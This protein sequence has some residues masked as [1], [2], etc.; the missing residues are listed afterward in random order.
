M[1]L[2]VLVYNLRQFRDDWEAAAVAVAGTRPDVALLQECGT[3]RKLHRFAE[4][5]EMRP[6]HGR[7]WPFFRLV[8]DAVLVRPPWRLID[9]RLHRFER[10]TRFYP[11]GAY[12]AQVG[13]SGVR[14]WAVSTHLGLVDEERVRHARELTD[15]A[16]SLKPP[17]LIGGDFNEGPDGRAV[18]WLGE[19]YFDA[20]TGGG[21]ETFPATDPRARIDML[22][23]TPEVVVE[24]AV[25]LDGPDVLQGSDHRPLVVDL[26]VDG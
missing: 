14:V 4:A 6:A 21:G 5:L 2:R 7:L 3:T 10:S 8:R 12:L 23:T 24:R 15:L 17:L 20:W 19:R 22:F 11:R 26:R 9:G 13:R 25:V 18:R 1:E 16:A